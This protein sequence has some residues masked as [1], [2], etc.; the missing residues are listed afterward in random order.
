MAL[1]VYLCPECKGQFEVRSPMPGADVAVCSCGHEARR[2]PAPA[3]HSFGWRLSDASH[4][5][6]GPRDEYVKDV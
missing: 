4:E 2:I 3:N 1:Y 5:R 6:F